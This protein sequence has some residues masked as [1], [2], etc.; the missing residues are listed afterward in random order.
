MN[1]RAARGSP[2]SLNSHSHP[3]PCEPAAVRSVGYAGIPQA[4]AK[5][6]KPINR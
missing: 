4:D 3:T 5:R 1:V 2:P 6:S